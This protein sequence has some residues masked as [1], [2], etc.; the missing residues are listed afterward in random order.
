MPPRNGKSCFFWSY[1]GLLFL[2][3]RH[4][5]TLPSP[6]ALA[7]DLRG[8]LGTANRR[9]V[10]PGCRLCQR[11]AAAFWERGE[12]ARSIT[13][14]S[15][16]CPLVSSSHLLGF[17]APADASGVLCHL[18]QKLNTNFAPGLEK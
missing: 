12:F 7:G 17:D 15:R 11:D 4:V 8:T 13:G 18:E 5:R 6:A 14:T 3:C 10:H 9:G 1:T 2:P 16:G